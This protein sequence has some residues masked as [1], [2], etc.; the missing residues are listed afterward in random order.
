MSETLP[1]DTLE[2]LREQKIITD[3]EVAL[4]HGDKYIAENV[5][6]KER[7]ILDKNIVSPY[8]NSNNISESK[9]SS[10]LLKG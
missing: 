3:N 10:Q 4:L 7:R 2:M 6:T 1:S 9:S 5:L 8:L